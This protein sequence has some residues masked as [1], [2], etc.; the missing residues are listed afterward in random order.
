[1]DASFAFACMLRNTTFAVLNRERMEEIITK[2]SNGNILKDGDSVKLI[3]DLKVKG[4]S[5]TLKR[6]TV[7]KNIKLTDD[8]EEVDCR[9]EKMGIVLRTE[10]LAK[11]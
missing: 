8:P 2:D 9:V 10:F 5:I 7:V 11:A 4:S 3:K 6:G 1:M